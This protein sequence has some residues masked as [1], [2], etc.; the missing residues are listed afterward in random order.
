MLIV[1]VLFIGMVV[2]DLVIEL[3]NLRSWAANLPAEFNGYYDH[4]RY[5]I[6]QKYL[7]DKTVSGLVKEITLIALIILFIILGGLDLIDHAARGLLAG[8]VGRGLVFAGILFVLLFLISLPFDIYDTFVIEE[9]YG[10][11]R[12]TVR[13]FCLD[14]I[15]M[16]FLSGL[17]GA[18]VFSAIVWL[19]EK[20]GALAWIYGWLAVALFQLLIMYVAPVLIMPLFNR[21]SP[22]EDGKL[23]TG[24]EQ[25]A[26]KENFQIQGIYTIDG[27]KRSS[28][29]NAA[30]T[31]FGKFKRIMLYDTLLKQLNESEIVAVLAH[32][33]GHY[34]HKHIIKSIL[35]SLV[36]SAVGFYL[37]SRLANQ[38]I[39]FQ[40]FGVQ[41]VSIYAALICFSILI[42]PIQRFGSVCS[43]WISRSFEYSADQYAA[44]A[45]NNPEALISA[46]KKISADSMA[47]LQ[48]HPVKVFFDYSHPPI[49]ERIRVLRKFSATDT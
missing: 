45:S 18:I 27:S 15:K 2:L 40:A 32:E 30:L 42:I 13:T 23:K 11:N 12:T 1:I 46:L 8:P 28:K 38:P 36:V 3:L 26:H 41:H 24:I 34:K 35:I 29:A 19:F 6:A 7:A 44:R 25:L 39:L 48:P 33:I 37:F 5:G 43:S 21:F 17:F 14:T 22:L 47:N 20:T 10:F 49:L 16:L 4:E 31:G 9:K